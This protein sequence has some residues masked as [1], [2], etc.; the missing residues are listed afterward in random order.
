[1]E[2]TLL[3]RFCCDVAQNAGSFFA[4]GRAWMEDH[5]A[6]QSAVKSMSL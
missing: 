2:D 5:V 3:G 6:K 4:N 1:M